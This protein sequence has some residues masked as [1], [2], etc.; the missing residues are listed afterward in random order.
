[1]AF[2]NMAFLLKINFSGPIK[3]WLRFI[4]A[5]WNSLI[6]ETYRI[7]LLLPTDKPT[8]DIDLS[9]VNYALNSINS[10]FV[11]VATSL[12]VLFFLIG[13]CSETTNVR[14]EMR[15]DTIAR[16]LVR[17]IVAEYFTIHNK[18]ILMQILKVCKAF[19]KQLKKFFNLKDAKLHISADEKKAIEA[20]GF[21][22]SILVLIVVVIIGAIILFMGISV[23]WTVYTRFLKVCLMIPFGAL[24]FATMAGPQGGEVSRISSSYI[25]AF[26]SNAISSIVIA[27]ALIFG[28]KLMMCVPIK[29]ALPDWV[30]ESFVSIIGIMFGK[31]LQASV[32]VA[33]VKEAE[34]LTE[35]MMGAY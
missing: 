16:Y 28:I 7:L 6:N 24:A 35:R 19:C 23:V 29:L 20:L 27:V 5:L 9:D 21:L 3:A 26:L 13:F 22:E 1:M 12:L 32:M 31:M 15:F 34:Y 11:A 10:I 8:D 14:E 25:K 18:K 33:C 17:L 30:S 2:Y 4:Y